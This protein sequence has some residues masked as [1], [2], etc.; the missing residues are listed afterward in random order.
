MG[1]AETRGPRPATRG[2]RLGE[3]MMR[4]E[5]QTYFYSVIVKVIAD[6]R[7]FSCLQCSFVRV[8]SLGGS[9]CRR[10]RKNATRGQSTTLRIPRR[11][12]WSFVLLKHD[13][14]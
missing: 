12:E 2:I 10:R 9:Y 7:I 6:N 4:T 3:T 5:F 1:S 13:E 14:E 11:F 8:V